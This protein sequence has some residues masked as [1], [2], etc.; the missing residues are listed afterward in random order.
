MTVIEP[1]PLDF[2]A[3]GVPF[4]ARYGDIYHSAESGPGQARHVFL[5]GNNLPMR[6][7]GKNSFTILEA[8][9]GLGLNFLAT[10]QTW[11]EDPRRC[12]RLHYAAVEKHPFTMESLALLHAQHK[13]FAPLSAELLSHWPMLVPGIHRLCLDAGRVLLTLALGD[14]AE[15]LP[16]FAVVADAIYLDGFSPA[17]NPE[18]WMPALIKALARKARP[19]STL[20]TYSS[21]GAVRRALEAEGFACEKRPGFG[22]KREMLCATFAPR[23]PRRSR[24]PGNDPPG[25]RHALVI[26][27]GLAGSAVCERLASRGWRITLIESSPAPA[28][29]AS[30]LRAGV[31][32]PHVSPDDCLL[33]R[34]TRHAYL[35]GLAHWRSLENHGHPIEW[36]RCGVLQLPHRTG[37]ESAMARTMASLNYPDNYARY[38]D[39][40][41]ASELA[42]CRV[43]HGGA[44]FLEGGWMRSSSL[45]AAQ[46]AAAG[47]QVNTRYRTSAHRLQQHAD[48]WHVIAADG[49]LIAAAPVA[50]LANAAETQNLVDFGAPLRRVRGTLSFIPQTGTLE[51]RVVLSGMGYALPPLDGVI[52]TGSTYETEET[53][54]M[55][56][57]E[58]H[59]ANLARLSRLLPELTCPPSPDSLTGEHAIRAVARDRLPLVGGVPDIEAARREQSRLAGARLHDLPRLRN[60]YCAT[61]FGSRGIIWSA[62]AGELLASILEGESLPIESNL[63]AAID[64]ARFVLRSLRKGR[65]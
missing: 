51:P 62:L 18:M 61:G 25:E 13:D 11:R 34:L 15:I 57:N 30:G 17:R 4:S 49:S 31:F 22:Q 44:W 39:A 36:S 5:G 46:L 9:F 42:A 14:A 41:E 35:Q 65:L 60:L 48:R 27:A 6:W 58:A 3:A 53:P 2:D 20:A 19:G 7:G 45:V 16:N 12:T 21:A 8:G 32:H 37:E 26:G 10:W 54:A 40:G 63:A 55:S 50:I 43:A 23:W 33:S 29:G 24:P 56:E 59:A 47:A 38:V 1:A 52:V 28:M 64:P